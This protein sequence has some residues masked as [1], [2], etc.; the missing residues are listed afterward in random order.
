M[1]IEE[2]IEW[3]GNEINLYLQGFLQNSKQD[4]CTFV[5]KVKLESGFRTW[6]KEA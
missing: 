3:T 6:S 1:Y 4:L 5:A 2:Y